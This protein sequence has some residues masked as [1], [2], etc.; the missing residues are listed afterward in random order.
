MRRRSPLKVGRAS[1]DP[2]LIRRSP[3]Q[4]VCRLLFHALLGFEA[5]L[6]GWFDPEHAQRAFQAA[7][8][9]RLT[10]SCRN[11]SFQSTTSAPS[12]GIPVSMYFH[13][14]TMSFRAKAT[15]PI[16]R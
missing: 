2:G 12:G 6:L 4:S 11:L 9:V 3:P 13:N 16:R 10:V 14:A 5:S 1:P 7:L 8:P 15:I